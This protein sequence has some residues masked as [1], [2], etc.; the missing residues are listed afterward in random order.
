MKHKLENTLDVC[1]VIA[2]IIGELLL[3]GFAIRAI[4]L[5]F[6]RHEFLIAILVMIVSA[7]LYVIGR[8]LLLHSGVLLLTIIKRMFF[9]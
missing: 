1:A 2:Y 5:G 6:L 7:I 4:V 8:I 3:A 9:R